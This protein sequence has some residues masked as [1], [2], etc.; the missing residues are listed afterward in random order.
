MPNCKMTCERMKAPIPLAMKKQ[1]I[2][3]RDKII[4]VYDEFCK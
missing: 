4:A 1:P 3:K 2:D